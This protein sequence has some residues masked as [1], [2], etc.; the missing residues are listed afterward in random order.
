[1]DLHVHVHVDV[2]VNLGAIVSYILS[3]DRHTASCGTN[4]LSSTFD[5]YVKW[6]TLAALYLK[7]SCKRREIKSF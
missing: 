7:D 4:H 1:M 3:V 2:H 5:C 6:I